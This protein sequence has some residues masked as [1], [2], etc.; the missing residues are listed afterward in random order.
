MDSAAITVCF[1]FLSSKKSIHKCCLAR[2]RW[3]AIPDVE[4]RCIVGI[5]HLR[6][7]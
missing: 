5:L 4:G 3:Q 1:T 7:K 2:D 6:M